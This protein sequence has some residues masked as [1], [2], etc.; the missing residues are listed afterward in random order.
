MGQLQADLLPLCLGWRGWE[1]G[2][3]VGRGST[4][5]HTCTLTDHPTKE[6]C[7]IK[8]VFVVGVLHLSWPWLSNICK[9]SWIP[10]EGNRG[11]RCLSRGGDR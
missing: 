4:C 11:L 3:C 9:V 1:D 10:L 8:A 5:T 2:S 7:R 6:G